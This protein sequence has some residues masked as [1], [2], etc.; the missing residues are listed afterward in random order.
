MVAEPF[1]IWSSQYVEGQCVI[2]APEG[3]KK[4]FQLKRGI[5]R[6]EGWPAKAVCAM[7]DDF[8]KDIALS[9]NLYGAGMTVVSKRVKEAL[10]AGSVKDVEYLPVHIQNHKGRIASSDYFIVNPLGTV[11]CVDV[12]ASKV[13]WNDINPELLSSCEQLVIKTNAVPAAKH[14]FRPKH[15]PYIL[16]ARSE[17]A[18]QME[19]AKFT[20]LSFRDPL[21]FDGT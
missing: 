19:R 10:E 8:P 15:V 17:L 1:L 12:K 6:L 3:L 11:E 2:R 4:N 7:S 18:K 21:E 13:K 20:G 5:S 16:L 9:D 14:L